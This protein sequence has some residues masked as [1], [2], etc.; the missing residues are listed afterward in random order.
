MSTRGD[1]PCERAVNAEQL[2]AALETGTNELN[3]AIARFEDALNKLGLGVRVEIDMPEHNMKLAYGR[4]GNLWQLVA[5]FDDGT[6]EPLLN[7]SRARRC[8]A[9]TC[10]SAL[11]TAVLA[12]AEEEIGHVRAARESADASTRLVEGSNDA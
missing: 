10:F 6:W 7:T 2:R 1:L 9:G 12:K 3:A 11:W 5:L 8:T 4:F